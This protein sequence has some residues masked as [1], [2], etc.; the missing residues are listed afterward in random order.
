MSDT[1]VYATYNLSDTRVRYFSSIGPPITRPILMYRALHFP[2]CW[3]RVSG[4]RA[5][6][7]CRPI[8]I[9]PPLRLPRCGKHAAAC[10]PSLPRRGGLRKSPR[11]CTCSQPQP[12]PGALAMPCSP[13]AAAAQRG[14]SASADA[15]AGGVPPV[16]GP[17]QAGPRRPRSKATAQRGP[18]GRCTPPASQPP[19]RRGP[20]AARRVQQER[21]K[22]R[23]ARRPSSQHRR[24]ADASLARPPPC[25]EPPGL[26]RDWRGGMLVF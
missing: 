5:R 2:T 23:D 17:L 9:L 8:I 21:R 24:L 18:G 1:F 16:C 19:P 13:A 12:D 20:D 14:G 11:Q 6:R 7:G 22:M 25:A 10:C 3:I 15:P 4:L 26:L